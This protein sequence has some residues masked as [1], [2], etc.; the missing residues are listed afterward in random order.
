MKTVLCLML[1][2]CVLASTGCSRRALGDALGDGPDRP[3]V[4]GKQMQGSDFKVEDIG[5]DSTVKMR[6]RYNDGQT[7]TLWCMPAPPTDLT[8]DKILNPIREKIKN[9][10][11]EGAKI[12]VDG[13]YVLVTPQGA[14]EANVHK[15]SW[16]TGTSKEIYISDALVIGGSRESADELTKKVREKILEPNP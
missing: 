1:A 5:K 9:E 15:L 6:E 16:Y 8:S 10:A 2:V 14:T 12:I 11:G 13:D 7:V 3:T 4:F